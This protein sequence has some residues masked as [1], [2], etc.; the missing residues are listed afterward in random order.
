MTAR[1]NASGEE[2]FQDENSY[3][4]EIGNEIEGGVFL[5]A[6]EGMFREAE[7]EFTLSASAFFMFFVL[8]VVSAA[9]DFV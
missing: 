8:Q 9:R 7:E 4:I 5:D 2:G 6:G 1:L 3:L